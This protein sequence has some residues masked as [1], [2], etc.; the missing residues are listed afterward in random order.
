MEFHDSFYQGEEE[1]AVVYYLLTLRNEGMIDSR[2][3][4]VMY[5]MYH[6]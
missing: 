6:K 3:A 5:C 2:D 4:D 1:A